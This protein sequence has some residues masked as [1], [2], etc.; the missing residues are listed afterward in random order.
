MDFIDFLAEARIQLWQLLPLSPPDEYGSP[1]RSTSLFALAPAMA[2]DLTGDDRARYVRRHAG[3]MER[4]TNESRTWLRDYAL[5][6]TLS[7]QHGADWTTWPEPLRRRDESALATAERTFADAISS[8]RAR[9]FV[10]W[11]RWREVK[12]AA[13]DHGILLFGD[14]PLYPAHSSADVWANPDLF[15][16]GPSGELHEVAGVPPDYFSADGQ[17]WGNPVYAWP[18]HEASGFMWW[19][20]R[21]RTQL[22]MF[23]VLRI[24]H[25]RGLEAFWSIPAKAPDATAGHWVAS[26]G[27]ALLERLTNALGRLPLVAEDLGIITP[28]VD[29]L[30]NEFQL[31]GMR[32]LQF[33]FSGDP[34]NPHLPA[35]YTANTVAYTGTHDNDTTLGWYSSLLDTA[36]H[37]VNALAGESATPWRFIQLAL[38]S[39]ANTAIVPLQD[40]LGLGTEAR[41]NIPGK[42]LGNWRWRCQ[43]GVLS[44]AL[45]DRLRQLV[46]ASARV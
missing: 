19:T 9:Q 42:T 32:V 2:G 16:L 18:A 3:D 7:Q 22:G 30:R 5:Y 26:P 27:R 21:I 46:E 39:I 43:E 23:D 36:L 15:V 24:D 25:F 38:D 14:V 10:A 29:R 6:T 28:E 12:R 33:A 1:Y 45:A 31:P 13:N 17:R 11:H 35:Q 8:V 4:F 41:M 20:E 37:A 44:A 40:L 34:H